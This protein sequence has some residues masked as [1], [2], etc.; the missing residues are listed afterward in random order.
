MALPKTRF[1]TNDAA[2][3]KK[4][5]RD[6]F[7]RVL[8][9][10]EFNY[11]TGNNNKAAV[12]V[13]RDL[14][15]GE[16]D[17]LKFS[18]RLPLK[19]KGVVG[20][21]T[22]EGTEE[23]QRHKNFELTIE[24]LNKAVDTGGKMEEQRI[25][26]DLMQSGRDGLQEWWG[27]TLSDYLINCICGNTS[28]RFQEL[29]MSSSTDAFAQPFT[30]PDVN[31]SMAAGETVTSA[32]ATTEASMTSANVATLSFFEAM[33][34]RALH[35]V[36]S[37]GFKMR[38]FMIKGK[39]YFKVLVHDF[40]FD[41]LHQDTNK[42]QWGDLRLAAGKLQVAEAEIVYRNVIIAKS[43]RL[44]LMQADSSDSTGQSGIYRCVLMGAQACCWAWGGAGD[45]KSSTMS[46]VPYKRDADRF[47]MIR[48]GGLFGAKK[49][50]F[51]IP[52]SGNE[53]YGVITGASWAGPISQ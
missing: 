22:V 52:G 37:E 50:Y 6:L 28:Y 2:T 9:A 18:I 26:W 15:K 32:L 21:N 30:E 49:V 12:H 20:R 10:V 46:F 41:M 17:S 3:R 24:E 53:D 35:P 29:D 4:W 1:A 23:K 14:G 11:L 33:A 48:G 43:P 27:N 44:P 19:E 34:Q 13:R 5:A 7:P 42:A 8:D 39:P 25:P 47:V 16:G 38:P 51:E 31:H 36:S 45:S 40:V